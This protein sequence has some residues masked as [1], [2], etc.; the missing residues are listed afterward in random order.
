MKCDVLKKIYKILFRI[1]LWNYYDAIFTKKSHLIS[2]PK[3]IDKRFSAENIY[4]DKRV[5]DC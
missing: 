4:L 5:Q 3:A 1:Y 2:Y